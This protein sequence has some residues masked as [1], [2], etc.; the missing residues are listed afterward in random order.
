MS[1]AND[2]AKFMELLPEDRRATAE[3]VR[4]LVLSSLPAG[5]EEEM[6]GKML[7][8]QVPLDRYSKL[9]RN[10]PLMYAALAMR[11]T[12]FTL[13]LMMAERKGRDWLARQFAAAGKKL[14]LGKACLHF[15]T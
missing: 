4:D 2:K 7:C 8:Y 3:A 11:K 6:R 12:G 13:H 14:N 9:P 1:T 5:Y 10:Q 15:E